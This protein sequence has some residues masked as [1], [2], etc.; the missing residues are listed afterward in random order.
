MKNPTPSVDDFFLQ[1]NRP[2]LS[3]RRP[4]PRDLMTLF[5]LVGGGCSKR[6][7]SAKRPLM[8]RLVDVDC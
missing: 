4:L 8:E 2:A 6:Y 7:A 1:K 5:R 3:Q